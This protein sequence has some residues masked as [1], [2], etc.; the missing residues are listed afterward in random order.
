MP[1]GMPN[2]ALAF[3]G[4]SERAATTGGLGT[5]GVPPVGTA[6]A[7]NAAAPQMDTPRQ[8]SRNRLKFMAISRPLRSLWESTGGGKRRRSSV[9]V[10]NGIVSGDFPSSTIS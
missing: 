8:T 10:F 6:T 7:G 5:G 9:S 3:A 4:S 1:A 2:A